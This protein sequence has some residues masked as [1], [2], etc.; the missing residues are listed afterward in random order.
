M[1]H[2]DRDTPISDWVQEQVARRRAAEEEH[3]R[4]QDAALE[5]IQQRL[6]GV[7]ERLQEV[8]DRIDGLEKAVTQQAASARE[9][10]AGRLSTLEES[11]VALAEGILS[12]GSRKMAQDNQPHPRSNHYGD[13]A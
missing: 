4:A 9:Q 6:G 3:V 13:T 5:Q 12:P 2:P 11:L 10:H 7:E 1:S 8:A